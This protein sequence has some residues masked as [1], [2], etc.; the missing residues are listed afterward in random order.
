MTGAEEMA[1]GLIRGELRAK[2]AEKIV[3]AVT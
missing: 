3:E 2:A 1:K